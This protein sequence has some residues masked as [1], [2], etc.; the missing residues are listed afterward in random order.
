MIETKTH[1]VFT[2]VN[3]TEMLAAWQAS[4]DVVGMTEDA[5]IVIEHA[6]ACHFDGTDCRNDFKCVADP[7]AFRRRNTM[8]GIARDCDSWESFVIAWRSYEERN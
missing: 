1:T 8:L 7:G 3:E 6:F 2:P 5:T 4:R